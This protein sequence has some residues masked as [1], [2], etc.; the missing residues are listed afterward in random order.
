MSISFGIASLKQK[1]QNNRYFS[2]NHSIRNKNN[3]VWY[4]SSQNTAFSLQPNTILIFQITFFF[5]WLFHLQ[6]SNYSGIDMAGQTKG[7][8][9]ITVN[10]VCEIVCH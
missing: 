2:G 5:Y 8:K 10:Q 4:L 1:L 6:F 9:C 3:S 7:M